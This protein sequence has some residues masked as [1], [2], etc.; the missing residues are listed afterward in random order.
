VTKRYQKMKR[1]QG[2]RLGSIGKSVT[3]R[4]GMMTPDRREVAPR[5][6]KR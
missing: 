3:R 5:R 2:T 6:E 1:M 4:S